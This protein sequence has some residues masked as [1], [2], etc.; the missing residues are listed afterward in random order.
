MKKTR[1]IVL[2]PRKM[3]I[4]TMCKFLKEN[5]DWIEEMQT[6][7]ID[8]S[9]IISDLDPNTVAYCATLNRSLFDHR[10]IIFDGFQNQPIPPEGMGIIEKELQELAADTGSGICDGLK[11]I[12]YLMKRLCNL[13]QKYEELMIKKA[14]SYIESSVG[15]I[16]MVKGKTKRLMG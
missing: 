10:S 13:N 3:G 9:N 4:T 16:E 8:V 6:H 12:E 14:L 15:K 11:A 5:L 7:F 2:R 1:G